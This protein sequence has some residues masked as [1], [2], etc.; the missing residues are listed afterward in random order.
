MFK[1][2]AHERKVTKEIPQGFEANV[3]L[4][5][6]KLVSELCRFA[7]FASGTTGFEVVC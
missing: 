7:C 3:P 5:L 1:I 4:D 2:L 6:C